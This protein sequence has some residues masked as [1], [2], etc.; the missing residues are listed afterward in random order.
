MTEKR[1]NVEIRDTAK[2]AYDRSRAMI[3]DAEALEHEAFLGALQDSGWYELPAAKI[4]G[5]PRSTF[6]HILLTRFPGLN[7][8]AS[9]ERRKL[10]Y[11]GRG[12]PSTTP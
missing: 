11:A 9:K 10:G 6:K 12:T 4:L 7:K 5:I 1:K 2:A 3:K 8:R